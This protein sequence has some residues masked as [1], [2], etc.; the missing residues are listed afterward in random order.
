MEFERSVLGV[1]ARVVLPELLDEAYVVRAEWLAGEGC[2]AALRPAA[3]ERLALREGHEEMVARGSTT[4]RSD[5]VAVLPG[6][7]R[8]LGV[9]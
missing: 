7:G 6:L 3:E 5:E 2:G 4:P 8:V 9:S 1:R